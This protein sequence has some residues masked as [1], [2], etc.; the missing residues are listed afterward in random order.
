MAIQLY[1]RFFLVLSQEVSRTIG[2]FSVSLNFILLFK[3]FK[4]ILVRRKQVTR[5]MRQ[6]TTKF[7]ELDSGEEHLAGNRSVTGFKMEMERRM[8]KFT[9]NVFVPT[10]AMVILSFASF[11]V[12]ADLV[13]G[14]DG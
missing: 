3:T 6:F 5:K 10:A 14:R 2:N 13:P 7:R 1:V 9:I 8:N 11:L 4:L 12:P